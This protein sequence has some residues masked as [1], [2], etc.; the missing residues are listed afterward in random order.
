[1]KKQIFYYYEGVDTLTECVFLSMIHNLKKVTASNKYISQHLLTTE[2]YVS[3]LVK[4]L[5]EKGYIK[6]EMVSNKYRTI[7]LTDK[8][9]RIDNIS[10]K[11]KVV[12]SNTSHST[13]DYVGS[14]ND[15]V[16]SKKHKVKVVKST[17]NKI[18]DNIDDKKDYKKDDNIDTST[19][20]S[21][22]KTSFGNI[23][24]SEPLPIN[25]L[26]TKKNNDIDTITF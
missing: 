26:P 22:V 14:T 16:G 10:P 15:Y 6:V 9:V 2:T 8:C 24:L 5:Q 21:I 7:T 4:K 3:K 20:T 19:D 1:M 25:P 18:E 23:D 13:N 11:S 12:K 17:T